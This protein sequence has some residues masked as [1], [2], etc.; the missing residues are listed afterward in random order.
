MRVFADLVLQKNARYMVI[1]R[2]DGF[3][4]RIKNLICS[5]LTHYIDYLTGYFCT[6]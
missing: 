3:V 5:Y 1:L 2:K 4:L 6:H